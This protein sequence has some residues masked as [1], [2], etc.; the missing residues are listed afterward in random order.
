M[1]DYIKTFLNL[2]PTDGKEISEELAADTLLAKFKPILKS[3]GKRKIQVGKIGMYYDVPSVALFDQAKD[4]YC[5]GYFISAIMVC[6][7]TAEYLAYE[8]FTEEVELNGKTELIESVA[9]NLDFRKI[10]NE[11]L[12]NK[13]KGYSIVDKNTHDLFNDLYTL[14]NQ[15]IH[16]KK[17]TKKVKIEYE[18]HRAIGLLGTLISSLRNISVDYDVSKGKLVKK[19]AARR[20][21][22][23]IALGS[24]R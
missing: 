1:P 15:W 2:D 6:R 7:S 8:I 19:S 3:I 12:Y 11:F 5:L 14:G 20:K 4:L 18:A 10:V 9:D 24:K 17:H 23:P 21:I 16:P 22:R 13:E